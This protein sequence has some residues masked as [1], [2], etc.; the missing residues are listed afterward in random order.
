MVNNHYLIYLNNVFDLANTLSIKFEQAAEAINNKVMIDYGYD[1][2]DLDDP[3]SWRYYQNISGTYHFSNSAIEVTSLDTLQVIPFDKYTLANHPATLEAYQYGTRYYNDLIAKYPQDELL[4]KGILY[5]CDIQT[6]IDSK[7]AT[8][9]SYSSRLIDSNEYSLVDRLQDWLYDHYARWVNKQYTISHDLYVPMYMAQIYMYLVPA[10]IN[11]RLAACKTSEAHS[12]HV[13][14]YLASNGMLDVYL[15]AMTK[16]QALFFYR[17]IQ[18]IEANAG[19]RDTF[20]WLVENVM[21]VRGLPLYE[22]DARH[23]LS[24]MIQSDTGALVDRPTIDFRRLP[25]NYPSVDPKRNVYAIEDIFKRIQDESPGNKEYNEYNKA[26]ISNELIDADSNV[27]INKIVESS[28]KDYSDAV[29][30]R[31][32]DIL[33]HEW[34]SMS[35]SDRFNAYVTIEFPITKEATTIKV[36]EAFI[37]YVYCALKAMGEDPVDLPKVIASR[38]YRANKPTLQDLYTKFEGSSLTKAQ[39][40]S[41]FINNPPT[42]AVSSIDAFYQRALQVYDLTL[43][44]YYTESGT[45]HYMQTGD[46]KVANSQL[47]EDRVI[48]L[49]SETGQTSYEDWLNSYSYDFSDYTGQDYL[50]LATVIY[51]QATGAAKNRHLSIKEIQRA[52]VSLF[53]R[54]SSYSIQVI[55]DV[56]YSGIYLVPGLSV[57]PGDMQ[58]SSSSREWVECAI[59]KVIGNKGQEKSN[60][61]LDQSSLYDDGSIYALERE[62]IKIDYSEE[63][64]VTTLADEYSV[65]EAEIPPIRT[66]G[67]DY[68]VD[69]SA[70]DSNQKLELF[71]L[72]I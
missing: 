35:H 69:Y 47:F 33:L 40:Q 41:V 3:S 62:Y 16:S 39:I 55:S 13:R 38:V 5:P 57:K 9:L 23:N 54:L 29:P 68:S 7:D 59:I 51:E 31:L 71:E 45:G 27:I 66:K 2:V 63:C 34:L 20:D 30:Y 58:G 15:N 10:I 22:Y 25:I 52:M 44:H 48:Q 6:A 46:L 49:S 4:I 72:N 14:Q 28:I 12:F 21:T 8:I 60:V 18:Y 11:L 43:Q 67:A 65:I 24:Q 26:Q 53:A 32:S 17:N 1:A 50:N 42:S 64:K 37:L 70:L 56:N 19:K 36:R 61:F